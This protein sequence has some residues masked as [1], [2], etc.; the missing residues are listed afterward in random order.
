MC[1]VSVL[2]AVY[3]TEKYLREC[4]DSLLRQTLH[5]IQV[6]C[7]DDCSTDESPDILDSYALADNRIEVIHL[8]ENQGQAHARNVGLKRA[9]GEFVCFLDSDDWMS[10][11]CLELAVNCFELHPQTD[12][13]L[14]DT[15]YEYPDR[16]EPYPMEA[17]GVMSGKDAFEASLTWKIHGVYIV[18]ANIHHRFPYDESAR[19][20][21]DDNTT[22][23]HYFVSREVRCCNGQY[24]YRQHEESVTHK[25]TVR[26]FDY[27]IANASMK[28]SLSQLCCDERLLSIYENVR[29][30]NVVDA[31]YFIYKNRKNLSKEDVEY[32][33]KI[34]R[35][36]WESIETRRLTFRNKMKL[37]YMPLRCSWFLF[38]MQEFVYFSLKTV[39]FR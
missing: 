31:M 24:H 12:S 27:L 7:V 18:R 8:E 30:L 25:P 35:T 23:L 20:Y 33:Y 2:V 21:S 38:R 36:T 10:D 34:I 5:D 9:G 17:F 29:W 22:R 6:I 15:I 3:N 16:K 32:G 39:L 11:D 14:F 37:G 1:K 13:V 4:L 28:R 26:K 19:A